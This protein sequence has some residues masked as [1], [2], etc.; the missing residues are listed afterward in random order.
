MGSY[1]QSHFQF[2][3]TENTKTICSAAQYFVLHERISINFAV[4]RK[5][6]D[7]A[8]ID[9]YPIATRHLIEVVNFRKTTEQRSLTTFKTK[10]SE[11]IVI[12]RIQYLE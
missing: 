8:D 7:V 12:D 3:V 9:D 11:S 10:T 1:F 5:A 2:A 6:I 4:G